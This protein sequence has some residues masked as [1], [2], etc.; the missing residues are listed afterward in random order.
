M[1]QSVQLSL[2]RAGRIDPDQTSVPGVADQNDTAGESLGAVRITEAHLAVVGDPAQMALPIDHDDRVQRCVGH[3]ETVV[4]QRAHVVRIFERAVPA[5]VETGEL[6]E[7]IAPP[8]E[9]DDA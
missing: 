5:V 7:D 3:Q 6:S 1:R 2:N 8:R 4:R 9:L